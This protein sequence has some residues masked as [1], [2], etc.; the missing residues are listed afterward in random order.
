MGVS[1]DK[2]DP[3]EEIVELNDLFEEMLRDARVISRDLTEGITNTG[4]AASLALVISFIQIIILKDNLWRGPLYVGV[5]GLG[6][7]LILSSGARLL[8]KYWLL[9]N[10]YA[11][12]FEI[13]QELEQK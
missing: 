11:R 12:F 5:W 2:R 9:K 8:Q 7:A 10:R 4:V 3:V 6:F 1:S 13:N